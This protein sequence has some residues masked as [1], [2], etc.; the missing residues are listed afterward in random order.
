[1]SRKGVCI[2]LIVLMILS[3]C[4][5]PASAWR[6]DRTHNWTNGMSIACHVEYSDFWTTGVVNDV[7]MRLTLL[8]TGTVAEFFEIVVFIKLETEQTDFGIY[9]QP[10]HWEDDN[11]INL[12]AQFNVSADQVNNA[13]WEIFSAG[14]YY[15]FNQTIRLDGETEERVYYTSVNGPLHVNISTIPFIV[16]WPYPP[17]ILIG[18]VFWSLYFGV[19]RFNKRYSAM[20]QH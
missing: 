9:M 13:E 4:P 11:V 10:D 19:R 14:I 17:I 1:M 7:F 18:I 3:I 12:Y 15:Q 5:Q 16:Y 6:S 8:D 20:Q 2:G